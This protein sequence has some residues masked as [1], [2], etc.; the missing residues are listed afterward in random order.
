MH[1][2]SISFLQSWMLS[3]RIEMY[4]NNIIKILRM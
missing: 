3:D 4:M 2:L 1:R